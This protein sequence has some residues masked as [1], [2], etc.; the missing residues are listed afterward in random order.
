M[1]NQRIADK[2]KLAALCSEA[3]SLHGADWAAIESHIAERVEEMT[4]EDRGALILQV[5]ALLAFGSADGP[6]NPLH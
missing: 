2:N 6:S 4:G 5:R 1:K 3:V